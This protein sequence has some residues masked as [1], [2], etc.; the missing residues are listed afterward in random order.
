M[1]AF[2]H[3]PA[4]EADFETERGHSEVPE[5]FLGDC[6]LSLA[7]PGHGSYAFHL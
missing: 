7:Y 6:M 3:M 5:E 4:Q 1:M 2:T